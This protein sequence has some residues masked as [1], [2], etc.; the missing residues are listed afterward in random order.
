MFHAHTLT[1]TDT[2]ISGIAPWGNVILKPCIA[3]DG[4]YR[5]ESVTNR[6]K[7]YLCYPD[8]K[9]CVVKVIDLDSGEV[10]NTLMG[11]VDVV[12]CCCFRERTCELYRALFAYKA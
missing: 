10:V 2:T 3:G 8:G 6:E 1:P 4:W 5:T 7:D 12:T 9:N 11:H